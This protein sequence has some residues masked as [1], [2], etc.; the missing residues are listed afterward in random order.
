MKTQYITPK[1]EAIILAEIESMLNSTIVKNNGT[2]TQNA[3]DTKYSDND[4]NFNY[5]GEWSG[6]EGSDAK[7]FGQ[8][9]PWEEYK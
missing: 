5:G 3:D 4:G 1:T 2:I 7:S 8:W 9:E 6:E